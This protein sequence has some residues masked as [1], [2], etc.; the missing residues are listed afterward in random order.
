MIINEVL[1]I[2]S[3][4]TALG[5]AA[6]GIWQSIS[7]IRAKQA[8]Q[9]ALSTAGD[10]ETVKQ[11]LRRVREG[12]LSDTELGKAASD[13]Q[14]YLASTGKITNRELRQVSEGLNQSNKGG[15]RRYIEDLLTSNS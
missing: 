15:E 5:A 9:K 6:K 11:V 8:A 2:L 3:I 7:G 4:V 14:K 12:G 10:E 1:P 13:I